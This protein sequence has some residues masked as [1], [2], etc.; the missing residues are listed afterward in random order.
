[1]L[2]SD[3]LKR[4]ALLEWQLL[5]GE[6][7]EMTPAQHPAQTSPFPSI[8]KTEG[9]KS[10]PRNNRSYISMSDADAKLSQKTGKPS[11]LYYLSS[12]A[13]ETTNV[14]CH[15]FIMSLRICKQMERFL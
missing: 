2:R 15:P 5:K 7:K 8:E 14:L 9:P 6:A 13:V 3:R 1:L 12:M 10:R 4:K 11:R